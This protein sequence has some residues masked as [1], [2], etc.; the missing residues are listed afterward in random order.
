MNQGSL[1]Q[2]WYNEYLLKKELLDWFTGYNWSIP[3]MT[4]SY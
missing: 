3:I 1:E 4:F 2:N